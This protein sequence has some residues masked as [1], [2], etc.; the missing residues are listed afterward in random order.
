MAYAIGKRVGGAVI[1]NRLRRRLRAAMDEL[2]PILVPG[3]YLIKCDFSA[4]DLSYEQL[5]HHLRSALRG[6]HV[7]D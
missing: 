2:Q 1:R 6:A 7:L 3:L 5:E 4:K